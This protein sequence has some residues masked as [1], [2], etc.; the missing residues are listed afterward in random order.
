M[1]FQTCN[2]NKKRFR[3]ASLGDQE[4]SEIGE[5]EDQESAIADPNND[6]TNQWKVF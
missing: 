1:E 5:N 2:R 3:S 6:E 4:M